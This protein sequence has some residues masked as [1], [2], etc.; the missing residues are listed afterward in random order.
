MA[1]SPALADYGL[2]GDTRTAALVSA[3][4]GIDW[5]CAPTFDGDPV[6]GSLLGGPEAGTFRA[7]PALPAERII[8]R[9]RP[10][11][12]TL[13][14]V[15]AMEGG[16]L[17]LTEAMIAEVSGRLLPTTLLI[18]RLEATG[19][20]AQ[21]A[22]VFD[23]RFGE[24]HLRP[25]IR[26]GQH[27]VCDWGALAMSLGCSGGL[28]VEPGTTTA[29]TVVPGHP[30][31]LVLALA[32]AEPLVW[33]DP[34]TAWDLV[35]ADEARW[36][37]WASGI[38]GDVPFREAVLRSLLTL[39]LLTYSPSGAPVA[40]PTTSL[41]EDPGGIR[42][43]DY[44][45]AWPRDASIGIAAFLAL[46]KDGEALNFLNWLLHA[47]RLQRPRLPAL[48]T[49]TGGHVPRERTLANWP[50]YAGSAPV[51]T[52]NGAAHQHQLDGYG[53]VLD[54]AWN[55][56]AQGHR[57]NSETWRA[58]RGFTD[59][60]A[61]R[62]PEP[63]AGIWEIRDDPAQHVHSKVMGW[64]ALDRALRIAETHRVS[65]RRRRRWETARSALAADIRA[66]GFDP[67]RNTYTRSYGSSNLDSA[68]LILPV[69]G[70]ESPGSARLRGTVDAV[71]AELS[72]GYPFLY[73]YPP[74]QDG[75]PGD[76]GA[77]LPC[78]FWL[79]QAL[80]LTGRTAEAE[81]LFEALL[82]VG[83][84]L[85]LFSEEADPGTG[86][87]LGNY[88]QALTHAALV[89]AA[90]ALRDVGCEEPQG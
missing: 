68:L 51:R 24:R 25:R 46:G 15:W 33:V 37:D 26:Q 84:P 71:R 64:L 36:R 9:Y 41:P 49:L 55:L 6:F 81:E 52:G 66:R 44:R 17:T 50:G 82:V 73:R 57:L 63:D 88:P 87:L 30:V 76:E 77:F 16:T 14:T 32:Y 43:W 12:A 60:V 69:T 10:H 11:T 89:Q 54:A 61:R 56:A 78:S 45:F 23:P 18:R 28:R 31:V 8:R 65:T 3:D 74:G 13:E 62:W 47:S 29:V 35:D 70:F 4:G 1:P 83:G 67:A 58:M 79:A 39:K 48:L 2:L 19:A 40:A 85:G 38:S 34:E 72:A 7:G 20:P 5:F 42:N 86:A 22:V 90:L 59:L 53:W 27:L 80:A 21:A 75:L